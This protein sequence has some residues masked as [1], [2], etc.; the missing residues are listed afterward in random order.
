MRGG[1]GLYSRWIFVG[2]LDEP[3]DEA[4]FI[5]GWQEYH[6]LPDDALNYLGIALPT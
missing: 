3:I 6:A 1:I 2:L 4:R 5:A